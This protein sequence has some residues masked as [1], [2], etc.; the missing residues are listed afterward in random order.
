MDRAHERILGTILVVL[1]VGLLLFAVVQAWDHTGDLGAKTNTPPTAA[2]DW[3]VTG[4]S[5]T[6]TDLSHAGSAAITSTY[7]V[8]GDGN[9]TYAGNTSHTYGTAGTYN[10]TLAVED[11]SG[12]IEQSTGVLIVGTGDHSTGA[13]SPSTTPPSVSGVL[14]DLGLGGTISSVVATVELFV[15]LA[16]ILLAGAAI[17][18]AGWNLITPKAETIQVR[19]KPRSLAIEPVGYPSTPALSPSATPSAPA[20]SVAAAPG[21]GARGST[22]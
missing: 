8:F 15:L 10:V 7:W 3:Q 6:F 2:F 12:N 13:G 4:F 14:G 9:S 21:V 19:V 20:G 16:V 11:A 17:L 18:R 5:V 22:P 1:G